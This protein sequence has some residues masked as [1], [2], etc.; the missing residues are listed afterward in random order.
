MAGNRRM[1][2][3]FSSNGPVH[4]LK[5]DYTLCGKDMCQPRG[6]IEYEDLVQDLPRCKKCMKVLDETS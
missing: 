3:I 2:G 4:Y 1:I 5:D 6:L